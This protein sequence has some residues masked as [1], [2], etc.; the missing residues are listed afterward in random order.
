[1]DHFLPSQI[2]VTGIV[3]IITNIPL[4]QDMIIKIVINHLVEGM[5]QI[6]VTTIVGGM[7]GGMVGSR[8]GNTVIKVLDRVHF[9]NVKKPIL[10]L[11]VGFSFSGYIHYH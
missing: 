9:V 7:V 4:H 3:V 5:V 6:M 10:Y 8:V 1:M 2:P 11:L